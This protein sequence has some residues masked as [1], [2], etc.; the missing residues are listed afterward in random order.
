MKNTLSA[1][2]I[3]TSCRSLASVERCIF[4]HS[5]SKE[6]SEHC[7]AKYREARA[8]KAELSRGDC[9]ATSA[10]AL[11]QFVTPVAGVIDTQSMKLDSI[12][13]SRLDLDPKWRRV[14]GAIKMPLTAFMGT[15]SRRQQ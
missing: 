11:I 3:E 12:A 2:G 14:G 5:R 15:R 1:L 10:T 4:S 6:M 13:A 7:S 9:G 8:W